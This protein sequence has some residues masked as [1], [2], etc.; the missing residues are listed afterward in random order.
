M[1]LDTFYFIGILVTLTLFLNILTF[2]RHIRISE[3][4][5]SFKK[6]TGNNPNISDYREGDYIF[7]LKRN[8]YSIFESV[9]VL[10]G[11]LS[12]NWL[13][14]VFIIIYT[15]L[16]EIA[17]KEIRFTI[18]GK[19]MFFKLMLIKFIIYSFIVLNNFY[20]HI[21]LYEEMLNIFN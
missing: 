3:W 19:V 7:L 10:I 6:V 18:I 21:N 17:L 15:K 5:F 4:L 9:W 2:K 16:F 14:F 20:F 13:M 1:L 11:L 12:D 8:I